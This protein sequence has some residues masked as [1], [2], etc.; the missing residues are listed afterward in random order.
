MSPYYESSLDLYVCL[1]LLSYFSDEIVGVDVSVLASY[2]PF[3]YLFVV[4]LNY[5]TGEEV[6]YCSPIHFNWHFMRFLHISRVVINTTSPLLNHTFEAADSYEYHLR[7]SNAVSTIY[8]AG[9]LIGHLYY[10]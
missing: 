3:T 10:S 9:K 4:T 7:V 1:Y 6:D 2:V 8:T 5:K